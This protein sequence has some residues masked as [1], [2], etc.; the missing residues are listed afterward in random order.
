[1]SKLLI[2]S[3]IDSEPY[4]M[5]AQR[6]QIH[7]FEKFT[8]IHQGQRSDRRQAA[9]IYADVYAVILCNGECLPLLFVILYCVCILFP[10]SSL[11]FF[12][13]PLTLFITPRL[14]CLHLLSSILFYFSLYLS[15]SP[16]PCAR[17][18]AS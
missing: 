5:L 18:S 10:H 15:L 11:V 4:T 9:V 13:F 6:G 1:M 2:Q 3:F 7:L 12:P 16:P 14:F 8:W 17:L